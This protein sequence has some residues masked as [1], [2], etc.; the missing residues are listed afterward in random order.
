M[1]HAAHRAGANISVSDAPPKRSC[2]SR[3][4][5]A[6]PTVPTISRVPTTRRELAQLGPRGNERPS[7]DRLRP[8]SGRAI[9]KNLQQSYGNRAI[10]R[11]LS[12]EAASLPAAAVAIQSPMGNRAFQR[13]AKTM[14]DGSDVIQRE[15]TLYDDKGRPYPG[16]KLTPA[17]AD[18]ILDWTF[19]N[20]G[21]DARDALARDKQLLED[22]CADSK[23][24]VTLTAA[25]NPVRSYKS[26]LDEFEKFRAAAASSAEQSELTASKEQPQLGVVGP[27]EGASSSGIQV[28]EGASVSD[29]VLNLEAFLNRCVNAAQTIG[30]PEVKATRIKPRASAICLTL[31]L[32]TSSLSDFQIASSRICCRSFGCKGLSNTSC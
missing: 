13:L 25:N 6:K 21:R 27:T 8:D 2:N 19:N 3:D 23:T 1:T 11:L 16:K 17:T 15:V 5:C 20:I 14:A 22:L 32:L 12:P 9:A 29:T 18:Q 4:T 31:N 24:K 7:I 26:F 28:I 30:K 10:G